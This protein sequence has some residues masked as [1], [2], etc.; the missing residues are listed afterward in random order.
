M[1]FLWFFLKTRLKVVLELKP[2]NQ[3]IR[4]FLI[5]YFRPIYHLIQTLY[6][7]NCYILRKYIY[8]FSRINYDIDSEL[9]KINLLR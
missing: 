5:L 4:E 1:I 9:C 3:Y 8:I 7:V 6:Y 2:E